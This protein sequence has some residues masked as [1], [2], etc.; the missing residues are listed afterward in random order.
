MNYLALNL[1]LAIVWMFL[2]GDFSTGNL[3]VGFLVGLIGIAFS[4]PVLGSRRYVRS[5][6]GVVHLTVEFV[7]EL[8]VANIHL[9]RDILRPVPPFR[10][11]FIRFDIRDLGSTQT[12]L[13]SNLVSL[14]PGT[15]TVDID[16]QGNTLY[17]HTLYAQDPDAV[18]HGIRRFA[19]LIHRAT[20]SDPLPDEEQP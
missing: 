3:V 20:G 5:V 4:R 18:R 12:V 10:P 15:L 1:L 17:V 9:A 7:R 8:V 14:T 2:Y 19:N 13:L 11:G 16:E 6:L